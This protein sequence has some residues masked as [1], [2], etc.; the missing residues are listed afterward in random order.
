MCDPFSTSASEFA[1]KYFKRLCKQK[2]S[3][4][5]LCLRHYINKAP[6]DELNFLQ[7]GV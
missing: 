3:N 2:K 6:S 5:M 4:P 1:G 7:K